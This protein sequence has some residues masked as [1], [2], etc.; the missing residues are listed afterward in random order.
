MA[1]KTSE[2]LF[3]EIIELDKEELELLVT[4]IREKLGVSRKNHTANASAEKYDPCPDPDPGYEL[5]LTECGPQNLQVIKLIRR[6]TYRPLK[7]AKACLDQLPV[8]IVSYCSDDKAFA[9]KKE[10]EEAGA[11]VQLERVWS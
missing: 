4:A 7:E 9:M 5:I 6:F 8:T 11:V 3:A 2:E 10:F 1:K